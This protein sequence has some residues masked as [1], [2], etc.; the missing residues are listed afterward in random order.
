MID[1]RSHDVHHSTVQIAGSGTFS[2]LL[3]SGVCEAGTRF[4]P[5]AIIEA[6][7]EGR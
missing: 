6:V 7:I 3:Q 5:I 1:I 2:I 4:G